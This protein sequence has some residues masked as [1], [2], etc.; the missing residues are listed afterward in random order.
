[1]PLE[2]YTSS[3]GENVVTPVEVKSGVDVFCQHCGGRMRV[4]R[5]YTRKSG[6]VVIRHFTHVSGH[7]NGGAGGSC[8][9]GGEGD[10]H[11]RAKG[12][13]VETLAQFYPDGTAESERQFE[14]SAFFGKSTRSGDA[15][16]TF[17]EPKP[18]LGAGIVV[19]VQDKHK[20]KNVL[21]TTR[22]Y[23]SHG[24]SVCW[25][26]VDAFGKYNMKYR[27]PEFE[28]LVRDQ[29][30]D[31]E[32]VFETELN[33]DGTVP[34]KEMYPL[35]APVWPHGVEVAR[36]TQPRV[37][38]GWSYA[39]YEYDGCGR[40][41][42]QAEH[43]VEL[44]ELK[45]MLERTVQLPIE[46]YEERARQYYRETPWADLFN[47][48]VWEPREVRREWGTL[49]QIDELTV[50]MPLLRWL[51]KDE[52]GLIVGEIVPTSENVISPAHDIAP[53]NT[54][55]VAD[56][57]DS[58]L[59]AF[60]SASDLR[61]MDPESEETM[62]ISDDDGKA[63]IT[64]VECYLPARTIWERIPWANRFPGTLELPIQA[65]ID[66]EPT[67]PTGKIPIGHWLASDGVPAEMR[68]ELKR[69]FEKGIRKIP[70]SEMEKIEAKER[71][72]RIVMYNT[73]DPQ[74]GT[75]GTHTILTI[76][77]HANMSQN[78][79]RWAIQR[80]VSNGIL[81]EPE[82]NRYRLSDVHI[83]SGTVKPEE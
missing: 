38:A 27:K 83:E 45:A 11:L 73:G 43:E 13:A 20:D 49:A 60:V 32:S 22:A 75:I 69:S 81:E 79:V 10:P 74:S 15:V 67:V 7:E 71:I 72:P 1:M 55:R 3:R 4:R 34:R 26:S 82:P 66:E 25:L 8:S 52:L 12:I 76:A 21:E 19:E 24:Y 37:A 70:K 18:V 57:G 77:S 39:A 44:S 28:A 41:K 47:S 63:L 31:S 40:L 29:L 58:R 2:A 17:D 53:Q 33:S 36:E 48:Y 54:T 23:L 5:S 51:T 80:L 78:A 68:E 35:V 14:L 42:L 56:V 50:N 61:D 46:W 6:V 62:L 64:E 65:D 16:V 9:G 30:P 59:A